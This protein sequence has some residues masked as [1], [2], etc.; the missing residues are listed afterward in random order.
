MNN[1]EYIIAS[2]PAISTDWK[3][4][5]NTPEDYLE[6]IKSQC[7]KADCE[8]I[9]FLREGLADENLDRDFYLRAF[10]HK[11]RFI[12]DY[13]LFDMNVRNAKVRYLNTALSREKGKDVMD[14]PEGEFEQA[15]ALETIF[16]GNDILARERALDDLVWD[17][18]SEL[19]IFNY[20]DINAILGFIAKL[21]I[22]AR[23]Y[24]LDER[25]GRER[26][27]KLVDEVRGTFKGVNY[28]PEA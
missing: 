8:V 24:K 28:S 11:N 17:K 3:F 10:A 18:I 26:F 21:H 1:Y 13:F 19:T 14:L 25:T 9:D 20:F 15:Q 22:V 5:D 4:T 16:A 7:S 6:E 12:R 27:R 23:W 2:L